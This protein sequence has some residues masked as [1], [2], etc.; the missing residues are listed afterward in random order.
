MTLRLWQYG[1]SPGVAPVCLR[2]KCCS[3]PRH[4]SQLFIAQSAVFDLNLDPAEQALRPSVYLYC[5]TPHLSYF[6]GTLGECSFWQLSYF[7]VRLFICYFFNIPMDLSRQWEHIFKCHSS[8]HPLTPHTHT[9]T[10]R[11]CISPEGDPAELLLHWCGPPP[12]GLQIRAPSR[13]AGPILQIHKWQKA[14]RY[15]RPRRGAA[16]PF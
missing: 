8:L 15:H 2:W 14:L 16:R 12:H 3:L 6:S 7:L 1:D 4:L 10:Y 9:H 13:V 5:L 11:L